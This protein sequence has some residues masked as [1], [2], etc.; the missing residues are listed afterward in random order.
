MLR[1][2]FALA[3]LLALAPAVSSCRGTTGLHFVICLDWDHRD[4]SMQQ[5]QRLRVK[6]VNSQGVYIP[7]EDGQLIEVTPETTFPIRFSLYA[8]GDSRQDVTVTVEGLFSATP[9][10]PELVARARASF[11]AGE[12]RT[13]PV[14]LQ[15]GCVNPMTMGMTGMPMICPD[16]TTTCRVI[17]GARQCVP[18]STE[19][20]RYDNG[21]ASMCGAFADGSVT[22]DASIDVQRPVDGG[23]GM[24]EG[25]PLEIALTP[26]P[27]RITHIA[28]ARGS[29]A[30]QWRIAAVGQL[31]GTTQLYATTISATGPMLVGSGTP[32]TSVLADPATGLGFAPSGLYV[33]TSR[34]VV[35]STDGRAVQPLPS[36]PLLN[37]P[38][39]AGEITPMAGMGMPL[40]F[41]CGTDSGAN[42]SCSRYTIN[43]G[44]PVP[45]TGSMP[46][47]PPP[48]A[49]GLTSPTLNSLAV[50]GTPG[51]LAVGLRAPDG[52]ARCT[53][54]DPTM[55]V[56]CARAMRA[57]NAASIVLTEDNVTVPYALVTATGQV[58]AGV[59]M[60]VSGTPP[61]FAM[62]PSPTALGAVSG[63]STIS[64][65]YS[66]ATGNMLVVTSE[67]N[68][69]VFSRRNNM[70][71]AGMQ[72][73]LATS[74]ADVIAALPLAELV[75]GV[76]QFLVV[77]SAGNGRL[78]ARLV[79][80]T[81]CY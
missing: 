63:G 60:Y 4:T 3:S 1:S 34:Q 40:S 20:T 69:I 43:S 13:I 45:F 49:T 33:T 28:V 46:P 8:T 39:Y 79:S 72:S 22:T 47:A 77:H 61:T 81:Q 37:A 24:C 56:G 59:A 35:F 74:G 10:T 50:V 73:M 48:L 66:A 71:R 12:L 2:R 64:A 51:K 42:I 25:A 17:D 14:Q 21:A 36:F 30:Q 19:S 65:A 31:P 75:N 53:V 18:I 9:R 70:G 5:L 27:M 52:F 7:S 6:V 16:D 62:P 55:Q 44:T 41:V 54:L 38:V 15:R 26:T 11:V 29:S 23:G 58:E 57:N 76:E 67:M 68:R 32:S 78:H 80:A